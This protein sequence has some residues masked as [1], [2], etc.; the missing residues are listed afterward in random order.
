MNSDSGLRQLAFFKKNLSCK[1]LL[2]VLLWV[3]NFTLVCAEQVSKIEK[4]SLA[5]DIADHYIPSFYTIAQAQQEAIINEAA[6]EHAVHQARPAKLD[7]AT[8][9]KVIFNQILGKSK[10]LAFK[11]NNM[12]AILNEYAWNDLKLFYGTTTE[13]GYHLMSRINKTTT[14]LG[15]A[16]LATLLV[17]PTSDLIILRQRQ[18]IIKTLLANSQEAQKLKNSLEIYKDAEQSMVSFW[19]NTDPLYSKEYINYMEDKFYAKGNDASN[20]SAGWLEWKKRFFRDFGGIQYRFLWFATMPLIGEIF[21]GE[22][23]SKFAMSNI[24]VRE[25]LWKG[26]IPYYGGWYKWDMDKKFLKK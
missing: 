22:E 1:N 21:F 11:Q 3:V 26:A 10:Q 24:T 17:T 15:E 19:T 18:E 8:Q 16:A 20:K 12:E 7:V 14:T 25:A 6:K 5:T 13:P 2:T 9:R 4:P 23:L